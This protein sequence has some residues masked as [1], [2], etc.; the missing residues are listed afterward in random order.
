LHH[1]RCGHARLHVLNASYNGSVEY[2]MQGPRS[3]VKIGAAHCATVAGDQ[4]CLPYKR[5]VTS[6]RRCACVCA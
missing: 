1:S 4:S 6:H 5:E 3:V 2:K